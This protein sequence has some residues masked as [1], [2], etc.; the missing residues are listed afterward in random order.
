MNLLDTLTKL[1]PDSSKRTLKNWLAGGRIY[2]DGEVVRK[3]TTPIEEGQEVTLGAYEAKPFRGIRV[4]YE[5]PHLVV[6]NKPEGLLSFPLDKPGAIHALGLLRRYLKCPHIRAVHRLDRETSGV[7]VF[8]KSQQGHEGL[9]AL[10]EKRELEREY[11]AAVEGHVAEKRGTWESLLVEGQNL[12]V[13]SHPAIVISYSFA[14][15]NSTDARSPRCSISSIVTVASDNLRSIS[16]I[17]CC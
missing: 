7:M 3:A 13:S 14:R 5:D 4:L 2:V 16:S 11:V 17:I 15:S 12:T 6:I 9:D 8:A 10:F 1:F